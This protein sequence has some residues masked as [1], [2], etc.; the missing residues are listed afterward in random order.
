MTRPGLH[1]VIPGTLDQ[2]TGGYIY[3]AHMVAGLRDLGWRVD[4]HNL[5]GRFPEGGVEARASLA[6]GQPEAVA[7]PESQQIQ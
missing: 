7:M 6:C 5:T 1:I 2:C 3:D 4:V